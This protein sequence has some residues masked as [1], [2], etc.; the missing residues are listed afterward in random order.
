MSAAYPSALPAIK[1]R[2]SAAGLSDDGGIARSRAHILTKNIKD[3]ENFPDALAAWLAIANAEKRISYLCFQ[4]E[5][6]ANGNRHLQGAVYLTS[7]LSCAGVGKIFPNTHA[8]IKSSRSSWEQVKTYCS[9]ED[10][11]V[12]DIE[13]T[14]YGTMPSQGARTDIQEFTDGLSQ[15]NSLRSLALAAPSTFVRNFRG[16]MEFDNLVSSPRQHQTY[17]LWLHGPPGSGKSTAIREVF[18]QDPETGPCYL[19][20]DNTDN[21]KW[22]PGTR[23]RSVVVFEDAT[24]AHFFKISTFLGLFDS[25]PLS[26][27]IKG[28]TVQFVAKTFVITSNI[29]PDQ[30]FQGVKQTFPAVYAAFQRRMMEFIRVVFVGYGPNHDLEFCPCHS[31][32]CAYQ[33]ASAIPSTGAAAAFAPGFRPSSSLPEPQPQSAMTWTSPSAPLSSLSNATQ[34]QRSAVVSTIAAA[35]A[36]RRK[37]TSSTYDNMIMPPPTKRSK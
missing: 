30:F 17:G 34:A 29:H 3:D 4:A 18:G 25:N 31:A 16:L 1:A 35:I 26:V 37:A 7:A 36:K 33:H 32:K 6:G 23:N 5:K 27:P 10:T 19:S 12:D 14:E 15:G 20:S 24:P 9:K 13:F 22:F 2:L 28:S 21:G 8:I 11:R